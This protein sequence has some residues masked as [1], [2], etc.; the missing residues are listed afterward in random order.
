LPHIP[1]GPHTES[2]LCL[3]QGPSIF[4]PPLFGELVLFFF[5]PRQTQRF[6]YFPRA[7]PLCLIACWP[8]SDLSFVFLN[9]PPPTSPFTRK[10][11]APPISC[12]SFF[13][14]P[15]LGT[16]RCL[17]FWSF[18]ALSYLPLVIL[19][20]SPDLTL[21]SLTAVFILPFCF[22]CPNFSAVVR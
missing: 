4:S 14:F 22:R 5:F 8:G 11:S 12:F 3:P 6:C 13:S 15:Q 19:R 10:P 17:P 20:M 18:Q 16:L 7:F 1:P 2:F 9:L 21:Q